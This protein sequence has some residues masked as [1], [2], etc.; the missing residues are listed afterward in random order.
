MS[1][2]SRPTPQTT[3]AVAVGS[4]AAVAAAVALGALVSVKAAVLVLAGMA[5][6]GAAA[7]LWLPATRV[8]SVR[9]R[10]V[11]VIIMVAFGLALAYLGLTAALT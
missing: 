8:F 10:A 4:L 5:F 1:E 9:R 2:P 6:A 3:L 7:R 11:D